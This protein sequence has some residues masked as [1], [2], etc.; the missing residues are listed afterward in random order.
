MEDDEVL[1]EKDMSILKEV[2]Y[3]NGFKIEPVRKVRCYI[4]GEKLNPYQK[5]YC[6]LCNQLIEKEMYHLQKSLRKIAI[7][8]LKIRFEYNGEG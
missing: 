2:L 7:R 1:N 8:I 3:N 4:C 6:L 5:K